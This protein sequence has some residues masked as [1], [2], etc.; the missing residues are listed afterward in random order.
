MAGSN[1]TSR[2]FNASGELGNIL[3]NP[4]ANAAL[5]QEVRAMSGWMQ[6]EADIPAAGTGLITANLNTASTN[7]VKRVTIPETAGTDEVRFAYMKQTT[8]R[9]TYGQQAPALA[10]DNQ[11]LYD[12]IKIGE[13][14]SPAF[15]VMDD[16]QARKG[17]N[18]LKLAGGPR[19][20]AEANV[21]KWSPYQ[22]AADHISALCR[23]ASDVYLSTE[24]G[25]LAENIGG[26]N[27]ADAAA[28]TTTTYAG[29]QALHEN[30]VMFNGSSTG[31]TVAP[32][33]LLDT[34]AGRQAHEDTIADTLLALQ[35]ASTAADI[36]KNCLTRDSFKGLA[37]MAGLWNIEKIVGKGYDYVFH[38]D[39]AVIEGLIGSLSGTDNAANTLVQIWKN[40]VLGG[41]ST[42]KATN[43]HAE[44]LILDGILLVPDRFMAGWRPSATGATPDGSKVVY[45]GASS[46]QSSYWA[47]NKHISY[48]TNSNSV[49][50][51]F[52][53]GNSALLQA[54]DKSLE[55]MV[56]EGAWKTGVA[57]ASREYRT[58]KRACFKGRDANAAGQLINTGSIQ[59]MS[60]IPTTL[61]AL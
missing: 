16:L 56:E 8:G 43:Y 6:Y 11:F 18:T 45:G 60:R 40:M 17:Y 29:S 3:N 32:R 33:L 27:N 12:N 59:V 15:R 35:T 51:G 36:A 37:Y 52:L 57:V 49:G 20:I 14:R 34:A 47:D 2:D 13:I 30:V 44:N 1:F 50:V 58:V 53:L 22:Y 31:T 41:N 9:A 26:V 55:M 39:W 48:N 38:A 46:A 61:G 5:Q 25:A 54:N 19:A 21:R 4:I 28:S 23:G 42:D 10:D 7:A 24:V